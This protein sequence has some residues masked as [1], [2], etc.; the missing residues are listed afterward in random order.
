MSRP[1]YPRRRT[2]VSEETL[3]DVVGG[4]ADFSRRSTV[5]S[6]SGRAFH[7]GDRSAPLREPSSSTKRSRDASPHLSRRRH[8]SA[9]A[10]DILR[11]RAWSQ[12]TPDMLEMVARSAEWFDI[13]SASCATSA[14]TPTTGAVSNGGVFTL[15]RRNTVV[16]C[17][18]RA[19]AWQSRADE[20]RLPIIAAD[21]DASLSGPGA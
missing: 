1:L 12:T 16:T 4:P 10:C 14:W 17:D 13:A 15:R 20:P 9:V 8:R 2:G 3:P 19:R 5:Q 7:E 18:E 21:V 11:R 6:C